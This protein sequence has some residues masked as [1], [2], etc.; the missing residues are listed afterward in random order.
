V[1][2]REVRVVEDLAAVAH[3]VAERWVALARETSAVRGR[4]TVALSGG[5]TPRALFQLLAREPFRSRI[6]WDR[7]ELFWGDERCVPPDH[8]DSNYRMAREHLLDAVPVPPVRVHRIEAERP[9]HPAVAAAYQAEIARVLGGT[10][11][12]PP[13]A[14]DL[15]LLGMGPDGHTAS[16]FPGTAALVETKQ[17]VVANHVPKFEADRITL[18][19]PIL[20]RGAHVVFMAAGA[21]KT[22]VL[23]EV[24]EGPPDLT[25]LPSQGV[26]PEAGGPLWLV[27][28]AAAAQLTTSIA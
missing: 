8:A 24:L 18:T 25:R 19:Y 11:G 21:D 9:D 28:R 10:P 26:R 5:S 20:N 4:F 15:I 23:R 14:F 7:V 2:G 13:P 22:A 3:A 6:A 17:W 12:G 27:D 16:L 1:S